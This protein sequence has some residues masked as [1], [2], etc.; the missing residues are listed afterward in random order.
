M[1]LPAS[2]VADV[3]GNGNQIFGSMEPVNGMVDTSRTGVII[4]WLYSLGGVVARECPEGALP[5]YPTS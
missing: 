5:E 2:I 3:F 1:L 4:G